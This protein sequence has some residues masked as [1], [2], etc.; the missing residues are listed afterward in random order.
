MHGVDRSFDRV[1]R[2]PFELAHQHYVIGLPLD[3]A[4]AEME[5]FWD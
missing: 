2:T 4:I 1:P 5:C 3:K